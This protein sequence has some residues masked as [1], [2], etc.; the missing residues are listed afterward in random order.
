MALITLAA[1]AACSKVER[2][3]NAAPP[4]KQTTAPAQ[5]SKAVAAAATPV[6][7]ERTIAPDGVWFTTQRVSVTTNDGII[8][9][10]PGTEVKAVGKGVYEWQGRK[11]KLT[12][13]QV[14]NDLRVAQSAAAGHQSQQAALAAYS[15]KMKQAAAENEAQKKAAL[16]NRAAVQ[17]TPAP[18]PVAAS[19]GAL[20]PLHAP[21]KS[22]RSVNDHFDS[23]GRRYHKTANGT[24][25]YD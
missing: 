7:V 24:N 22:Q 6:P 20:N 2:A 19:A 8:G 12:A 14:T 11:L 23:A 21:V 16:A 17:H 18:P 3:D 4:E 13:G 25:V 15:S 10:E 5:Q 1:F 9:I